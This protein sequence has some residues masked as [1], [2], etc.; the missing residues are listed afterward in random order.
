MSLQVQRAN[1]TGLHPDTSNLPD[2]ASARS[3][4]RPGIG[5][6]EG[7]ESSRSDDG[8]RDDVMSV[9]SA[10]PTSTTPSVTGGRA[11]QHQQGGR[12]LDGRGSARITSE[13]DPGTLRSMSDSGNGGD[14]HGSLHASFVDTDIASP[15]HNDRDRARKAAMAAKAVAA[16]EHEAIEDEEVQM[17]LEAEEE[18]RTLAADREYTERVEREAAIAQAR[19]ERDR[20][21]EAARVQARADRERAAA[22]EEHVK[23][24]AQEEEAKRLRHAEETRRAE[25]AAAKAAA[26]E[27][28]LKAAARA[29]ELEAAREAE[30]AAAAA[31]AAAEEKKRVNA[32]RERELAAAREAEAQAA[33]VAA[34]AAAAK[35]KEEEEERAKRARARELEARASAG[36]DEYVQRVV[37]RRSIEQSGDLI[38]ASSEKNAPHTP[39]NAASMSSQHATSLFSPKQPSSGD[40]A[41]SE[42]TTPSGEDYGEDFEEESVVGTEDDLSVHDPSSDGSVRDEQYW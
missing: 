35:A 9:R 2:S 6:A 28:R 14:G 15:A 30:L 38:T 3:S 1:L 12:L 25:M 29:R 11:V 5:R 23:R 32:Q 20:M 22:Q 8:Q 16:A 42:A 18:E 13:S 27:Q 40:A 39:I 37:A 41:G 31:V 10:A 21:E 34:A 4:E 19:A 24:L 33:E 36:L 17:R 26:E 7:L